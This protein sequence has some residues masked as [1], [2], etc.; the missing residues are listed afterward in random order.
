MGGLLSSIKFVLL[1]N[2]QTF[3][4]SNIQTFHYFVLFLIKEDET[5]LKIQRLTLSFLNTANTAPIFLL[6]LP[7]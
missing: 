7:V 1:T 3:K 6:P 5:Y 4:H 2:I